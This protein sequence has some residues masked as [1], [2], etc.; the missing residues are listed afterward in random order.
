MYAPPGM[1]RNRARRARRVEYL[2]EGEV[3]VPVGAGREG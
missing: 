1:E 2:S 3:Y